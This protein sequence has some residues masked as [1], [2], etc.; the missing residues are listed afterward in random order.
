MM[1]SMF[2]GV[3]GLRAHQTMM[4][5]VG[6]NI[7]NVNTAGYKSSQVTFQEA[8]TQTLAGPSGAGTTRG[9]TNPLQIGLGVKVASIDGVFTQGATQVTGR[10]TDLAVQGDG[11]FVLER[12]GQRVYSRAGSFRFDETGNLVAPGGFLVQGWAADTAGNIQSQTAVGA[13]QLPLSQVVDPVITSAVTLGGNLSSDLA[14]GDSQQTSIVIYDS[15]GEA[16]ELL[17]DITKTAANTWGIAG[18]VDGNAVTLSTTTITFNTDGSLAA[19][20]SIAVS[21]WTPPGADPLSFDL[22][23]AGTGGLVQF[24]GPVTAAATNQDGNP[25]GFLSDFAISQNGL[26]TG[27]FSNGESKVLAQIATAVFSNPSGLQR[28]GESNFSSTVNSGQALIGEPG[29]GSRGQVSAG[30]LEMSNVDLALE[31]TNL[32]IAQR[33]FQA[34]SRI[35]TASDEILQDLV[36]IKR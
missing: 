18:S 11:F 23:L 8:L 28:L 10:P 29:G 2:S 33:G 22:D 25:I 15:L 4:D 6:Q 32:I 34:N 7:A 36:N 12:G 24:G 9:G 13:L 35:I 30:A 14:V 3:S 16:R 26:I 5:I 17:V 21:G 31:F 1:R 27:Q 20:A 19:P